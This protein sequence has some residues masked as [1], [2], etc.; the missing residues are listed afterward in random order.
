MPEVLLEAPAEPYFV[1]GAIEIRTSRPWDVQELV[2]SLSELAAL[3]DADA[4]IPPGPDLPRVLKFSS[5]NP[6]RAYYVFDEGDGVV[7]EGQ[8]IR[9]TKDE[10]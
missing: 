1:Q 3:L 8:A 2:N 9:F 5:S 6:Y 4:V 7:L 10:K